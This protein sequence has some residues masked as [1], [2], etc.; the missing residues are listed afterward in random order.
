LHASQALPLRLFLPV[1]PGVGTDDAAAL[2]CAPAF[3]FILISL[4]SPLRFAYAQDLAPS[5]NPLAS[6]VTEVE[7]RASPLTA[8]LLQPTAPHAEGSH[9]EVQLQIDLKGARSVQIV[10]AIASAAQ[11]ASHQ[12]L[13]A[14][15]VAGA[16][17]STALSQTALLWSAW[18]SLANSDLNLGIKT[19]LNRTLVSII[20]IDTSSTVTG[21]A[22]P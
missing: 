7:H 17:V 22:Q 1:R 14:A 20:V 5:A 4:S 16:A 18:V 12:M 2:T 21:A 3:L 19:F 8:L 10:S 15:Q 6:L 11:N 13:S 9:D